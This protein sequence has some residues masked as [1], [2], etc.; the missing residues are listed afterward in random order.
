MRLTALRA[1]ELILLDV[2]VS[3]AIQTAVSP[4]ANLNRQLQQLQ[5]GFPDQC[6]KAEL[7]SRGIDRS[8]FPDAYAHFAR[9]GAW[10]FPSF[11]PDS[12][13]YGISDAHL[14]HGTSAD[15]R[16]LIAR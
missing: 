3:S 4:R 16:Q 7:Q 13:D 9:P 2:K 1:V 5:I 15:T 14:V 8:K 12:I 10:I 6:F 11:D